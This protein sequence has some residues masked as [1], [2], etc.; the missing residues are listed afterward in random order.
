MSTLKG[1]V[2]LSLGIIMIFVPF[3]YIGIVQA[4]HTGNHPL[5]I[6]QQIDK[7]RKTQV[8]LLS[9]VE[10][11]VR[12]ATVAQGALV[13]LTSSLKARKEKTPSIDDFDKRSKAAVKAFVDSV[14]AEILKLS[15]LT[16]KSYADFKNVV[17]EGTTRGTY[18]VKWHSDEG[19]KISEVY[20]TSDEAMQMYDQIGDFAK[21]LLSNEDGAWT[22]VRSYGGSQWL[23]MLKDND[24]KQKGEHIPTKAP[25]APKKHREEEE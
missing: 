6:L 2:L 15:Q 10:V 3:V 14:E 5:S 4:R 11:L 21:K 20:K 16:K 13:E 7:A 8:E 22:V 24:D 18:I 19:V 23:A 1:V 17:G 25:K 12:N 9:I